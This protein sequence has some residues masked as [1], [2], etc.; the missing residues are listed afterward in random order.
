MISL[1]FFA[2]IQA[3]ASV[4]CPDGFSPLTYQSPE[5]G[6]QVT[7]CTQRVNG[8]IIKKEPLGQH[9][10]VDKEASSQQ[11]QSL[12]KD[13][14][15]ELFLGLVSKSKNRNLGKFTTAKCQ[16]NYM[17]WA[18]LLLRGIETLPIKYWF[19]KGCSLEGRFKAILGGQF[20][21]KFKVRDIKEVHEA[22][23]LVKINSKINMQ[24]NVVIAD[25]EVPKMNLKGPKLAALISARYKIEYFLTGKLSKNYG[26]QIQILNVNGKNIYQTEDVYIPFDE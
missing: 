2:L 7:I 14:Y 17:E 18:K 1:L 8:K 10:Q 21:V 22:D 16:G 9:S 25:F 4:I 23:F 15:T 5:K 13:V 26:G 20:P 3:E 11:I 19:A 24:K 6:R 12:I